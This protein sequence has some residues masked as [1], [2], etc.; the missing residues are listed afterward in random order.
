MDT[1][2][3][4]TT[5]LQP[6]TKETKM[7]DAYRDTDDRSSHPYRVR[8]NGVYLRNKQGAIR[9]FRTLREAIAAVAAA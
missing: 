2:H 1:V 9:K 8:V 6:L 3:T 4:S 5:R 7:I